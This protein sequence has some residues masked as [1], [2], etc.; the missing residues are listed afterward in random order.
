MTV[1]DRYSECRL[2]RRFAAVEPLCKHDAVLLEIA[3][4]P[5]KCMDLGVVAT[6][7]QLQFLDTACAQ[8]VFCRYHNG[9]AVTLETV[10][11]IDGDVIDPAAMTVMADQHG[12]DESIAIA[13]FTNERLFR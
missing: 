13:P 7:H 5:I 11:R 8:P 1:R 10:V 2:W 6:D 4:R 12:C 9:A 3:E